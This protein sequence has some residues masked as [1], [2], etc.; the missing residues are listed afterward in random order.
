MNTEIKI[1]II[2]RIIIIIT[3]MGSYRKDERRDGVRVLRTHIYFLQQSH[4]TSDRNVMRNENVVI[5]IIL[6]RQS[7]KQKLS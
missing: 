7:S 4:S 3:A 6:F 1:K 2:E 5:I